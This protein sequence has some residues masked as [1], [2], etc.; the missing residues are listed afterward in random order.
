MPYRPSHSQISVTARMQVSRL[1]SR[2]RQATRD[3]QRH[4]EQQVRSLTGNGTRPPTRAQIE[5]VGRE[6]A[7]YLR[8]RLK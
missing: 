7:R 4:V 3:N 6:S 5:Q 1:Q 8:N 2:A